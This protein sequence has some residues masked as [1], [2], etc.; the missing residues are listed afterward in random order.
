[1]NR[2]SVDKVVADGKIKAALKTKTQKIIDAWFS[3]FV[4]EKD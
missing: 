1:M 3:H 2:N 4:D